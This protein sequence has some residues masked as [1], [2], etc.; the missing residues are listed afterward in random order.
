MRADSSTYEWLGN[1]AVLNTFHSS[2][3][4]HVVR[5]DCE[6]PFYLKRLSL[7]N[8]HCFL[9]SLVFLLFPLLI[10]ARFRFVVL[11]ILITYMHCTD[12]P[13]RGSFISVFPIQVY[14]PLSIRF[15]FDKFYGH[16]YNYMCIVSQTASCSSF[17]YWTNT[18]TRVILHVTHS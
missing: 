7:F 17:A 9:R 1:L 10:F 18:E 13:K 15:W 8:F 2:P 3:V 5:L 4:H 6:K 11:C 16:K 12:V 14:I